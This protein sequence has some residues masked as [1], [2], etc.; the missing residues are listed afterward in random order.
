MLKFEDSTCLPY[1]LPITSIFS[2]TESCQELLGP[3]VEQSVKRN[4][5]FALDGSA[6]RFAVVLY[7][8]KAEQFGPAQFTIHSIDIQSV[9]NER[10]C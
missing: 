8:D 9:N 1:R 5:M 3:R 6:H 7:H 10:L 2:D 4:V